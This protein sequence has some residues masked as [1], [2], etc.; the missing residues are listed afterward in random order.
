MDKTGEKHIYKVDLYPTPTNMN[1]KKYKEPQI[2]KVSNGVEIRYLNE[3]EDQSPQEQEK[4][5]GEKEKLIQK[6]KKSK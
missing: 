2:Y 5:K 6:L 3:P 4:I 1:E